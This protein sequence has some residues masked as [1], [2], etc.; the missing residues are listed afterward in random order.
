MP[1][2]GLGYGPVTIALMTTVLQAA[3]DEAQVRGLVKATDDAARAAM[4][5]AILA[6][7]REGVRDE[8]SLKELA[9]G[10]AANSH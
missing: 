10:A 6:A 5:S 1:F 3:W 8:R 7:V 9:L 4:A 2:A